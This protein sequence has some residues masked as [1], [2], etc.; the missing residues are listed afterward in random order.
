MTGKSCR[1]RISGEW[2]SR[3]QEMKRADKALAKGDQTELEELQD[4]VLSISKTTKFRI[5]LSWGGPQDFIE[6]EVDDS[7]EIIGGSYHF[8]DWFDGAEI[9]LSEEERDLVERVYGPFI[10]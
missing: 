1:E 4:Q 9:E 6:V 2:E 3:K 8:L 5:D 7:G 10:K